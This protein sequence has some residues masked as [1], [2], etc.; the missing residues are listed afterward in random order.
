MPMKLV[1]DWIE[2]TVDRD[3][4]MYSLNDEQFESL[5]A[6]LRD[7]P[8]RGQAKG[9]G[10]YEYLFR[11]VMVHYVLVVEKERVLVLI[12]G[13]RPP[14]AVGRSQELMKVMREISDMLREIRGLTRLFGDRE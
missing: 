8:R 3:R 5:K 11:H 9:H 6:A 7:N 10:H 14:E 13:V 1:I 12:M 4:Q 2:E